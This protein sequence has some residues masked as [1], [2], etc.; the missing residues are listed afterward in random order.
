MTETRHLNQIEAARSGIITDEMARIAQDED[1]DARVVREGIAT[2]EVVIFANK[3]NPTRKRRL[4][5]VGTGLRTKVNANIGTSRLERLAIANRTDLQPF[6]AARRPHLQVV[7]FRRVGCRDGLSPQVLEPFPSEAFAEQL[8]VLRDHKEFGLAFPE[9]N[10]S[11]LDELL[12]Q[13]FVQ[14]VL[15]YCV[16]WWNPLEVQAT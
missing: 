3:Q 11:V 6:A 16:S 5:A 15:D 8:H 4:C 1:L 2:G 12:Y 10:Q 14:G 9:A 7:L 13:P